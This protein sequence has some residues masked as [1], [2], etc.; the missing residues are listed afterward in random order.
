MDS[1]APTSRKVVRRDFYP[2][3][4]TPTLSEK[5]E[6]ARR[7]RKWFP[8]QKAIWKRTVA[9]K[10]A[11]RYLSRP[12]YAKQTI[13][14][15]LGFL[16]VGLLSWFGFTDPFTQA[17]RK[18]FTKT[19][20]TEIKPVNTPV[21]VLLFLQGSG[22]IWAFFTLTEKK[23]RTQ[24]QLIKE[25]YEEWLRR[26]E[27]VQDD[28]QKTLLPAYS[29]PN[30]Y[31]PTDP[32]INLVLGEYYDNDAHKFGDTA[33]FYTM[34]MKGLQTGG[35]LVLGV[36]GSGKTSAILAPIMRQG[37]GWMAHV[38]YD[39][40]NKGREKV[41]AF[42]VDPKGS[43]A[44]TAH[45]ILRSAG[46]DPIL[47]PRQLTATGPACL[48]PLYVL[49]H[50]DRE[51][52]DPELVKKYRGRE[53]DYLEL[54]YD[55]IR[56]E[57]VWDSFQTIQTASS[58]LLDNRPTATYKEI[59]AIYEAGEVVVSGAAP[60]APERQPGDP[61]VVLPTPGQAVWHTM[62]GNIKE[63]C[64]T[65][66]N[67]MALKPRFQGLD[68]NSR[69][70]KH[71][72]VL[73]PLGQR[74]DALIQGLFLGR[75]ADVVGIPARG[76]REAVALHPR[77]PGMPYC[78]ANSLDAYAMTRQLIRRYAP[79]RQS[80]TATVQDYRDTWLWRETRQWSFLDAQ[81]RLARLVESTAR[82]VALDAH[83][84][85][86]NVSKK[87]LHD[88]EAYATQL[89]QD[90]QVFTRPL[91]DH[92]G[93]SVVAP[94]HGRPVVKVSPSAKALVERIRGVL[95][96]RTANDFRE[97]N[98][99]A[100]TVPCSEIPK[101]H[102]VT[103]EVRE[104]MGG[105]Y[106]APDPLV[107]AVLEAGKLRELEAHLV[108]KLLAASEAGFAAAEEEIDRA[109][110][111]WSGDVANR[112]TAFGGSPPVDVT[113]LYRS[114]LSA[115]LVSQG[116]IQA[117]A[118]DL[119][120]TL[121]G[122][123]ALA[124][125]DGLQL[126]Q[127]ALPN[128]VG[129]AFAEQAL[130]ASRGRAGDHFSSV[131][132]ASDLV[133]EGWMAGLRVR[134]EA[135]RPLLEAS[136]LQEGAI[137]RAMTHSTQA[138]TALTNAWI[139][140]H[141]AVMEAALESPQLRGDMAE[142]VKAGGE[143]FKQ[144]DPLVMSGVMEGNPYDPLAVPGTTTE[145]ICWG[146]L[147]WSTRI[148]GGGMRT[149]PFWHGPMGS[150]DMTPLHASQWDP[151]WGKIVWSALGYS[152]SAVPLGMSM[153]LPNE[154]SPLQRL[155]TRASVLSAYH[156]AALDS[157]RVTV[158]P[159]IAWRT[160]GPFSFNCLYAPDLS[161]IV[162]AGTF[163]ATVFA[164]TSGGGK[165]SSDPFWENSSFTAVFNLLQTLTLVD[166]YATFP[167]I[168]NLVTNEPVLKEYLAVLRERL[169]ARKG[170]PEEL[171]VISNILKWADGEWLTAASSK[172]ETKDNIVR[173]LSVVSQP[174]K[175]PKFAVCFAPAVKEDISFPSWTWVMRE[176]KIVAANLPWE[177]Y[178]KIA[179]VV[180]PLANKTWQKAV[181]MRD[182]SR[183]VNAEITKQNRVEIK[184]LA[185]QAK[186]IEATILECAAERRVLEVYLG[187][188]AGRVGDHLLSVWGRDRH[189][190][191]LLPGG[192]ACLGDVFMSQARLS[193]LTRDSLGAFLLGATGKALPFD[194]TYLALRQVGR[195]G[196]E[197]GFFTRVIL[198]NADRQEAHAKSVKKG[199]MEASAVAK[200]HDT[201][202]EA[203][204]KGNNSARKLM[205]VLL[206]ALAGEAEEEAAAELERM[207][208]KD[209]AS[210]VK[211]LPALLV[212]PL[213]EILG[214]HA[215][216]GLLTRMERLAADMSMRGDREGGQSTRPHGRLRAITQ[217]IRD[218]ESQ[219]AEMPN[220]ERPCL[221]LCDE[222]HFF[223]SGKD[224]AQYVSVARSA[225]ALN[226]YST[227]SPNALMAKM[228]ESVAKQ[229][230]DNLPNRVILRMP[231]AKAAEACAEYLGGKRR[232]QVVETNV[233]QNFG[234]VRADTVAGGG[235]GKSEGGSVSV[236]MKE[237][238]RWVVDL[239]Q[240][241][242]LQAMEAY[243]MI[244]D[245]KRNTPPRRIYTKPDYLFTLPVIRNYKRV[246][247]DR[248]GDLPKEYKDGT[249]LYALTV[250]RLLEL[251][252]IDASR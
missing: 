62:S 80:P 160:D 187:S 236:S 240:I 83:L 155:A 35:M 3:A 162:V 1:T 154:P 169:G 104:R 94:E 242:N 153:A 130:A 52:F 183:A 53:D 252:V 168:D 102:G 76:A 165:Q 32:D 8:A 217:K 49:M 159:N 24:A 206:K 6:H 129:E 17:M 203:T 188:S 171:E 65:R 210:L 138:L 249:D 211:D 205:E 178:E 60:V 66:Q 144:V 11:L 68:W 118:R 101:P 234:D 179:Q 141:L 237:E 152:L 103:P 147:L 223:V 86:G 219:I 230:L 134:P 140:P 67:L 92:L 79:C 137:D 131:G 158:A 243:A 9:Y 127:L 75:E 235:R 198:M 227:Q 215:R 51:T 208:L 150:H 164:A 56:V 181:Q 34:K 193:A 21:V 151:A 196:I 200:H 50:Q 36:T 177:K 64:L 85:Y 41:A 157:F 139:V 40:D 106:A 45:A 176:G 121:L 214:R 48:S 194:G 199:A 209:P 42:I 184:L 231:D 14:I 13:G 110:E 218:L 172:S 132:Q 71:G 29:T 43:L 228:D 225:V 59:A 238:E 224:D 20:G 91:V 221:Y 245:G 135:I 61:E 69:S 136:G 192:P 149:G 113:H 37:F 16:L 161:P 88:S 30:P 247:G 116:G 90:L 125:G 57:R 195:Q 25:R 73:A 186:E 175:E 248:Y 182:G 119:V 63:S 117:L 122:L 207:G 98:F 213:P 2:A 148:I 229:F 15:A 120:A 26:Q 133:A 12:S 123:P 124:S 163:N 77:I 189:T 28:L 111:S 78:V 22:S 10:A 93:E 146:E 173:S 239:H 87:D 232:F 174:F 96:P 54:G 212:Q 197:A 95:D 100:L 72:L 143:L 18:G 109:I 204:A 233:S 128:A 108:I 115:T 191:M 226:F 39:P 19:D 46:I 23:K 4:L 84:P 107:E 114:L 97:G 44:G 126:S 5:R 7:K 70:L 246:K 167:K 250:P 185:R 89:A 156:I 33:H 201:L 58:R 244:W 81:V 170:R 241:V 145:R 142:L 105:R 190:P 27:I 220:T 55:E 82:L 74:T 47:D 38:D 216:I 251:G 99:Q 166:G 202:E 31:D 112:I 180:L 222:A